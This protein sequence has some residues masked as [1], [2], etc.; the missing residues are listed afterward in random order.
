[1]KRKIMIL[2]VALL[3]IVDIADISSPVEAAVSSVT[4]I[5]K[6]RIIETQDVQHVD[7]IVNNLLS[8]LNEN[9]YEKFS[10]YYNPKMNGSISGS[11]KK[12]LSR[13]AFAELH[14][15]MITKGGRFINKRIVAG[16]G[17]G[18]MVRNDYIATFKSVDYASRIGVIA[19][20]DNGDQCVVDFWI[21][22]FDASEV[23]A[24]NNITDDILSAIAQD[25]YDAF[26][27]KFS[28]ALKLRYSKEEFRMLENNIL[29]ELGS[30]RGKEN[31][32]FNKAGNILSV[33]SDLYYEKAN[34]PIQ[35]TVDVEFLNGVPI[36]KNI[37]FQWVPLT[38]RQQADNL[39]EKSL[40][41]LVNENNYIKFIACFNSQVQATFTKE[42]FQSL[43]NALLS[44]YGQYLNKDFVG[45]N[46]VETYE[47]NGTMQLPIEI[48][49]FQY[50]VTFQ[51]TNGP[52]LT[53]TLARDNGQL[54]INSFNINEPMKVK[55]VGNISDKN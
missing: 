22:W 13:E 31:T 26:S 9:D 19:T 36:V 42:K 16:D 12:K 39:A 44:K 18:R 47:S 11:V 40:S 51:N 33:S 2:A 10:S 8:A 32:F 7:E 52:N 53:M 17:S 35:V 38:M 3:L 15:E 27:E 1:V 54:V 4:E 6:E 48:M 24:T 28:D 14:E 41:A 5:T 25:K 46:L 55:Y 23:N 34:K 50:S 49:V 21:L 37:C 43:R 20:K 45:V 29:S 30:Y